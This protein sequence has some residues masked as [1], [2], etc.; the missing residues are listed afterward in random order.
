MTLRELADQEM[1]DAV[2]REQRQAK[3]ELREQDRKV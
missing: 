1:A 3:A 2:S